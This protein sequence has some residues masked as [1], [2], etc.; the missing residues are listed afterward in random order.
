MLFLERLYNADC[1]PKL[2]SPLTLA[3]IGDGVFEIFVRE[4]LVCKGNC[5]VKSLHKNSVSQVCCQAQAEASK[6]FLPILTEEELEV[7]KRGRNAHTNH[8]PKNANVAD[9]HTATAFEALFGYLYLSGNIERLRE[10][11]NIVCDDF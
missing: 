3:F 6:K 10:L 4:R 5:P 8:I 1:N 11:F 9:Y 2:L 7:F